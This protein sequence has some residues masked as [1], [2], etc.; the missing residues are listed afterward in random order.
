MNAGEL[1]K[2]GRLGEAVAAQMQE[3]RTDPADKAKRLFLF[4]LLAM[5]GDLD[6]AKRQIDALV[7]DEPELAESAAAYRQLLA[8]EEARR[9]VFRD[10]TAPEYLAEPPTH[11]KLRLEAAGL[12][13]TGKAKEAAA[14][15]AEAAEQTPPVAGNLNGKAFDGLRDCDDLLSGALEVMA[16]G[17]YYWV[18][19]EQIESLAANPPTA[20]RDL[21][22]V[23]A[24]L[25]MRDGP[26]GDVFLP[27]LYPG[28]HE[29]PDDAMKLGRATDWKEVAAG[30]VLGVGLRTFLAGDDPVTLLEWR[31]LEMTPAAAAAPSGEAG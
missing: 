23:P 20:P 6:R 5:A 13:R 14:R 21:V 2:A 12:L 18:P 16:K 8:S 24:H 17:K 9:A 7:F 29:H 28:S 15:L 10:G 3:V 19:L 11:L 26:D 30:A 22:W 31:E 27:A 1:F 4:E 25:T